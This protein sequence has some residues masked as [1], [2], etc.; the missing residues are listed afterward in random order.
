MRQK[1]K[2]QAGV[3]LVEV[4]IVTAI[5]TVLLGMGLKMLLDVSRVQKQQTA[6][7]DMQFTA[8]RVL[9]DLS[10]YLEKTSLRYV[11]TRMRV[12]DGTL[13]ETSDKFPVSYYPDMM[14][15]PSETCPFS[16]NADTGSVNPE[17][18]LFSSNYNFYN[19]LGTWYH[20]STYFDG[21]FSGKG[22]SQAGKIYNDYYDP[23]NPGQ[24]L[25]Q[26]DGSVLQKWTTMDVLQF[27]VPYDMKQKFVVGEGQDETPDWQGY[28]IYAPYYNHSRE[29]LELRRYS[30]FITDFF[31]EFPWKQEVATAPNPLY[32]VTSTESIR[33]EV[34]QV[35]TE[36]Y[37][38]EDLPI[39]D[40]T[41]NKITVNGD[42]PTSWGTDDSTNEDKPT[43]HDLFD[44]DGDGQ[45][46]SNNHPEGG[47]ATEEW[48]R[49]Y[50]SRSLDSGRWDDDHTD[51][52]QVLVFNKHEKDPTKLKG[53]FE[54]IQL[55]Y[56]ID[57]K[58]GWTRLYYFADW[59]GGDLRVEST[60]VRSR[61]L[62][63]S[64]PNWLNHKD[65][66]HEKEPYRT[67]PLFTPY[68][69]LGAGLTGISFSTTSSYPSDTVDPGGDAAGV[70]SPADVKIGISLD[71]K[72]IRGGHI[73]FSNETYQ[74]SF[75]PQINQ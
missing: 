51:N 26:Y 69:K 43:L 56:M 21:S 15:C 39:P 54:E 36:E 27:P 4:I 65:Y 71:Q 34:T 17:T 47:E 67:S 30:I 2:V 6:S 41:Y 28:L 19:D 49:L 3:T 14:Q 61:S 64:L 57:L 73:E 31:R 53:T 38:A 62:T 25:C 45:I 74:T 7:S 75:T 40:A 58:T 33:P 68:K 32:D 8:D 35:A 48:F 5:L 42:Y 12:K 60:F 20:N 10:S 52:T 63:G 11:D 37:V 29:T 59:N 16:W 18:G 70:R 24:T 22:T 66:D 46:E 1:S 23:A 44:F 72:I 50:P 55:H 13:Y 9:N